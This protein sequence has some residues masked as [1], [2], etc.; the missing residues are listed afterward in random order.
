MGIK[1]FCIRG[2]AGLETGSRAN[3]LHIQAVFETRYPKDKSAVCKLQ[4]LIKE[5]L[6]NKDSIK[7]Q[8]KAFEGTQDFITMVGYCTK[9]QGNK[10]NLIFKI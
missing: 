8:V 6:P 1:S 9:D 10:F 2:A 4:K 3:N 7:I 5:C